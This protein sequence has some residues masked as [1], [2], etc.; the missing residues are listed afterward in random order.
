MLSLGLDHSFHITGECLPLAKGVK[1]LKVSGGKRE[2]EIDRQIG[3]V[4]AVLLGT[5][6]LCGGELSCQT[7]L[8]LS[9]ATWGNLLLT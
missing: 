5:R 7:R 2:H 3:S 9:W 6:E 8:T 1:C 4:R